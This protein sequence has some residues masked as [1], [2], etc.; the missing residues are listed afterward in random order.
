L[1]V[2]LLVEGGNALSERGEP[3]LFV[4]AHFD[5]DMGEGLEA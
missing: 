2:S 1:E 3:R 4:F 5:V